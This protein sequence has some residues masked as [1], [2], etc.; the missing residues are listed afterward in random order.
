MFGKVFIFIALFLS[1]LSAVNSF[2]FFD[3]LAGRY[4][5]DIEAPFREMA[6]RLQNP[7]WVQVRKKAEQAAG[8][9][10]TGI[11]NFLV[12]HGDVTMHDAQSLR[13]LEVL[14]EMENLFPIYQ[15][16]VKVK[17]GDWIISDTYYSENELRILINAVGIDDSLVNVWASRG[18]KH[19]GFFWKHMARPLGIKA[20][21]G[22]NFHSDVVMARRHGTQASHFSTGV[23]DR[24]EQCLCASGFKELAAFRRML[25]LVMPP[26]VEPTSWR[27]MNVSDFCLS[28]FSDNENISEFILQEW[29][30][31]MLR[32]TEPESFRRWLATVAEKYPNLQELLQRSHPLLGSLRR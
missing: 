25:R 7:S 27:E 31:T 28:L 1:D 19:T 29:E 16:I 5:Y 26:G 15:N 22:D 3:T 24:Q 32:L 11:Y 17:K 21:I 10:L 2:D 13:A 18:D 12:T 30:C 4:H 6:H 23:L 14:V 20:H 9:D 8:C